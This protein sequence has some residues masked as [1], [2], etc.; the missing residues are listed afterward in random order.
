[1]AT[2]Q[3]SM[4][5]P[6]NSESARCPIWTTEFQR[7][8]ENHATL[9]STGCTKQFCQ[10]G[11]AVH[12]DEPRVGENRALHVVEQEAEEFLRELHRERF[13]DS[14]EKFEER[15]KHVR[16]EIRAGAVE[17]IV[18]E[19][20]LRAK[21]GGNWIQTPQEL[22]FGFRRAWRNSR[23]CIMRSHCEELE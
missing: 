1:M 4:P 19:D 9:A 17:A 15:L 23:K 21:V 22:Q 14:D 11:R 3:N 20:G 18:R 13:F 8:R 7:V 5:G 6:T 10:A 2:D 12:T 16:D